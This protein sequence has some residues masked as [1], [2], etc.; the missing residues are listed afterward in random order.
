M[1]WRKSGGSTRS[2]WCSLQVP[3]RRS[4][5]PCLC[6]S[7]PCFFQNILYLSP[8]RGSSVGVI[9]NVWEFY[10]TQSTQPAPAHNRSSQNQGHTE[11]Y[12][13][14]RLWS[15]IA[16]VISSGWMAV[17]PGCSKWPLHPTAN[18]TLDEETST[19]LLF[20]PRGEWMNTL[21]PGTGQMV[22]SFFECWITVLLGHFQWVW[23]NQLAEKNW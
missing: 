6:R 20:I 14:R 21:L 18:E 22:R 2:Q 23:Q 4:P 10:K 7:V 19:L 12:S 1:L 5:C 9:T 8:V 15:R 3:Q 17:K 11:S 16:R 13:T